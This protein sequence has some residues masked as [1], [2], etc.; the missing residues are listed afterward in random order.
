MPKV[1]KVTVEQ[2]DPPI[3]K[4]VLAQ[5]VVDISKAFKDLQKSGL[6]RKA[7]IVLVA[8]KASVYMSQVEIVLNALD[9]LADDYT[10]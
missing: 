5:A 2:S 9:R 10:K 7:I 4:K 6:N 3:D 1:T 8:H